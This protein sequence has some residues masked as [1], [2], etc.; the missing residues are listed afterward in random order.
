M[1]DI[2][3]LQENDASDVYSRTVETQEVVVQKK[4]E[5]KFAIQFVTGSA[6]SAGKAAE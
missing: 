6:K 3:E 1:A 5:D 2:D 4:K